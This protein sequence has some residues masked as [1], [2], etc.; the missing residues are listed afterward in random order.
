MLTVWPLPRL[1]HYVQQQTRLKEAVARWFFQ[2]LIIGVDYCHK[3]GVANRDI[4]LENT[5]LQKVDGLPLPLLKICDFGYSKA[6]VRSAAKSKVGTLTYMAPEV[7][8][9][10]DGKYDGKVADIWSCGVMLYVMFYGRYPFET[11]PGSTMPKATEILAML[12]NMVR[13]RYELPAHV[14]ISE[15]GKSLLKRM[16]LPD[17]KQR[18]PIEEVMKHPWFTTNLPPEAP[19]MN[20]SYLRAAFP[21]GHQSPEDIRRLLDEAK[22]RPHAQQAAANAA[23][24]AAAAAVAQQRAYPVPITPAAAPPAVGMTGASEEAYDSLMDQAIN[25]DL[26]AHNS[27]ELQQY[28]RAHR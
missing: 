18:I 12:D 27:A 13:Q 22:G 3:R 17:P 28:V 25:E 19:T 11:P 10:R 7:L 6:D 2:Q 16:L 21:A 20:E 26:R 4:K 15:A 9:N 8:V 1:F 24:N 5:L 23:A 14:E